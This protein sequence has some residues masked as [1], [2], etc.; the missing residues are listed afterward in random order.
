MTVIAMTRE[1]GS[2]GKDVAKGVADRL[3]LDL[4]YNQIVDGVAA[5]MHMTSAAVCQYLEGTGRVLNRLSVSRAKLA[6]FNKEQVI[7]LAKQGNVIIRG[8]GATCI[9]ASVPHV[10]RVRVRA[11]M[12]LRVERMVER[13]DAWG[14]DKALEEIRASDAAHAQILGRLCGM[15]DWEH[16]RHYHRVFDT[17]RQ[18]VEECVEQLI[19][20]AREPRFQ[21]TRYSEEKLTQL[22]DEVHLAADVIANTKSATEH[23]AAGM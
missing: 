14:G 8:W 11:P 4:V 21:P 20:L 19:S 18:P 16:E 10:I 12:A 13:I 2:L 22:A 23:S 7:E 3:G 1:M 5:N 15:S 9:L 17:A 6:V